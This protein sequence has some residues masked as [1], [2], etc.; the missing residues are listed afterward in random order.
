MVE[1]DLH[2]LVAVGIDISHRRRH[3]LRYVSSGGMNT[4]AAFICGNVENSSGNCY[5]AQRVAYSSVS[6]W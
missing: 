2:P 3:L 1:A 4:Q 6:A 5:V